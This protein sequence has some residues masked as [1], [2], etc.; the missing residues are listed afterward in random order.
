MEPLATAASVSLGS[1]ICMVAALRVLIMELG[2]LEDA[3][4]K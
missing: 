4:Q 1:V 3:A 2:A